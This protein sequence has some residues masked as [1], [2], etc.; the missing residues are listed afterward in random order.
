MRIDR[1]TV[2]GNG[3]LHHIAPRR[4]A[5]SV[6][7]SMPTTPGSCSPTKKAIGTSPRRR[8]CW[9]P[10]RPTK[11]PKS[12]TANRSPIASSRWNDALVS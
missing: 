2:A 5:G 6:S 9:S 11:R 10:M 3:V 12:C 1:T 7:W 8:S 4:G